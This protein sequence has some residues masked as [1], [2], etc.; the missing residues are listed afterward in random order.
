MKRFAAFLGV[1][2][3]LLLLLSFHVAGVIHFKVGQ[4][5]I[6]PWD[7]VTVVID[8]F[9]LFSLTSGVRFPS[10]FFGRVF[11]MAAL[12]A[13]L[14]IW[15]VVAILRSPVP[16][17][18]LTQ[19][20]IVLRDVNLLLILSILLRYVEIRLLNKVVFVSTSFISALGII[21]FV[22]A[23]NNYPHIVANRDLW[24]PG[25][26]YTLDYTGGL[27]LLGLSGDPNF[28]SLWTVPAFLIGMFSLYR[29]FQWGYFLGTSVIGFSLLLAQSRLFILSL[30]IS[31]LVVFAIFAAC[32]QKQ[33]TMPR[34]RPF[35][36][37][38]LVVLISS[39][40]AGFSVAVRSF[41]IWSFLFQRFETVGTSPRFQYWEKLV[42]AMAGERDID[43]IFGQGFRSTLLLVQENYSH[44]TFIDIIFETGIVGFIIW[45]A[46]T[47][48]VTICGLRK[49][50]RDEDYFPWI[51][52]WF[53]LLIMLFGFSLAYSPPVFWMY[54]AL[55]LSREPVDV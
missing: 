12:S 41:D 2:S 10:L 7:I 25:F 42:Y 19:Y 28:Y 40:I 30:V 20:L 1:L 43:L 36:L 29:K 49:C 52:S 27:R 5:K 55:L 48:F 4:L 18:A 24:D 31:F 54:S 21:M 9:F 38:V 13:L 6:A 34:L 14:V 44:N 16:E 50:S 35:K 15:G 45:L 39:M 11:L 47:A 23:L 37:I 46:F 26:A 32:K 33:K 53:V 8:I 3:V 51:Q 22:F 17:W